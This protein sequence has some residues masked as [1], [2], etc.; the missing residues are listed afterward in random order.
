MPDRVKVTMDRGVAEVRLNR[1][2]KA[3]AIDGGMFE[4][5][6]DAGER[7]R[8]EPGLRA[9]V[10]SGEG[11]VFSSGL[12]VGTMTL[13][14]RPR[15]T[16]ASHSMDALMEQRPYGIANRVQ[17][18]VWVW[19]ELPVPVIAAI[20]GMAIG[21]GLQLVMGADVR[22]AAPNTR[23]ALVEVD[24]GMVPDMG[25]TQLVRHLTRDDV[26]RELMFSGRVFSGDDAV[27]LGL[28]TRTSLDPRG[29]ALRLA[30]EIAG[31]NPDAVRA[32]TR[33]LNLARVSDPASG[34]AHETEE[35]LSLV[36]SANQ[37]EAVKAHIEKRDPRFVDQPAPP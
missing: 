3:N 23:M 4:A 1:P 12:D 15:D 24:W 31:K 20:H 21:T 22:I 6:I 34:L 18:A 8:I 25:F 16:P 29:D 5:I 27:G 9:V 11:R 13:V 28:V 17:Y 14:S 36:G 32:M 35:Q 33:L 26:I 30:H 2:D 7:L 37:I 19:R 10:I